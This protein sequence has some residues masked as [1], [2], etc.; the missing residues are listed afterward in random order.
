MNSTHAQVAQWFND[1]I[2]SKGFVSQ[3]DA[4]IQISERFGKQYTYTGNSGALCIDQGVLCA[5]KKIK[6]SSIEY[7]RAEQCWR[8]KPES[9]MDMSFP[10]DNS[11]D[12]Q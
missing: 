10:F 3:Y 2:I 7:Y 11:F 6:A 12:I 8:N 9:L 4:V 1:E 5:F